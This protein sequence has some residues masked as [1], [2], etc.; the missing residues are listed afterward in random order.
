MRGEVPSV[1][2]RNP[3]FPR[4]PNILLPLRHLRTRETRQSGYDGALRRAD[5][6]TGFLKPPALRPDDDRDQEPQIHHHLLSSA[7]A[8]AADLHR[9]RGL[10]LEDASGRGIVRRLML[11][12]SEC[13]SLVIFCFSARRTI[14][15]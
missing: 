6:S 1:R 15:S 14:T 11:V 8:R 12:V 7:V 3:N 2:G 10:K 9:G 4:E 13:L 5:S